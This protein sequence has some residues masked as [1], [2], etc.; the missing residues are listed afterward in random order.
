M[1]LGIKT[2]RVLTDQ[3]VIDAGTQGRIAPTSGVMYVDDQICL[4]IVCLAIHLTMGSHAAEGIVARLGKRG[5]SMKAVHKEMVFKVVQNVIEQLC[6]CKGEWRPTP[7]RV[8]KLDKYLAEY[9]LKVK[10]RK[11]TAGEAYT[12][13]SL[14]LWVG[15][16]AWWLKTFIH[17]LKTPLNALGLIQVQRITMTL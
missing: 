10:E 5:L 6:D 17:G 16:G 8:T 2:R 13:Y 4:A 9:L 14:G 7:T 1:V 11:V 12:S 15:I 3:E